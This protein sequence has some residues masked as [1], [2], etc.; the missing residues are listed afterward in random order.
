MKHTIRL[1]PSDISFEA[2]SD[3]AILESAL[4][5]DIYLDYSCKNGDCGTCVAVLLSGKVMLD[6]GGVIESGEF[7]TCNSLPLSS[8]EVEA[9]Y[10][11]E[12][13]KLSRKTV[14]LKVNSVRQLSKDVLQLFL[15][16][17]PTSKLEYISGQYIDLSYQGVT[18]SYSIANTYCQDN[19]LELHIK[20]VENGAMSSRLF[21]NLQANTLMRAFGPNGTFFVRESNAPI[22]FLVTGTG[23]APAKAMIENLL[24][25]KG[26]KREIYLL[27]GARN[28]CDLYSEEPRRWAE[29]HKNFNYIP[30]LSQPCE[31]WEG[32]TGYVQAVF[33][34]LAQNLNDFHVYACGSLLMIESARSILVE[35]GLNRANF[36]SDAFVATTN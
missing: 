20:R 31:S 24:T 9:G 19:E 28:E 1:K 15:R 22:A 11:S 12:L 27:W 17:P 7:L 21:D 2:A 10:Y 33:I 16:L 25:Q 3:E 18:R 30:V 14:P 8:I 26:T 32:A 5:N 13:A 23:F 34:S 6:N 36:Y 35:N 4:N 29:N